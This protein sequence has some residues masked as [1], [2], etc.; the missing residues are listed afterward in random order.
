MA[1]LRA[2]TPP[3]RI[4]V[5]L[6]R[7]QILDV[8]E[9]CL[10]ELGYDGTTIRR[11]AARLNCAVGTI[12]RYFSDKRALL[13]AV[14]QRRFQPVLDQIEQGAPVERTAQTYIALAGD[15]PQQYRLMFW[16][17]SVQT[18]GRPTVP[19]VIEQ[20][21]LGWSRQLGDRAAAEQYWAQIHGS[22]MLGLTQPHT[23]TRQAE[24]HTPS[25]ASLPPTAE[26]A[27]AMAADDDEAEDLTLL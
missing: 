10:D 5:T 3:V 13:A 9:A 22:L 21:I 17:A 15:A 25:P 27:S 18:I 20:I 23:P 19:A 2:D 7:A 14:V 12:Y 6:S 26:Y 4:A 11:I 1:Q 16:L 24:A 8:T